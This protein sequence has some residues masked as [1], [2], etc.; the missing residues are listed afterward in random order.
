[1]RWPWNDEDL[2]PG[3]TLVLVR[4]GRTAWNAERRFLGKSDIPLD[5]VGEADAVA[6]GR[7]LGG[8][9]AHVYA[10]P[11][12]RAWR[13][14]LALGDA[15]EP[16]AA[17]AEL[18]QGELE[19]LDLPGA[20]ARHPEFFQAWTQDPTTAPAPGG[21]SLGALHARAVAAVDAIAQRH[22]AGEV[23]GVVTHQMVIA[24]LTCEALGEPLSRWRAH[25]VPNCAITAL[26]RTADGWHVLVEGWRAHDVLGPPRAAV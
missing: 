8:R 16:V 23:V 10:S 14:A 3:P 11:L 5:E 17:L 21:E 2:P 6:L 4:H 9:F 20:L 12:S 19:G 1:M 25:G 7:V 13:T 24:S 26:R 22:G 15:P 18:D